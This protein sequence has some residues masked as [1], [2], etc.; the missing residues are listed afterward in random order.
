MFDND[1]AGQEASLR[2]LTLA[3][4]NNIFP[5]I[6]NLPDGFKDID[7]LANTPDGKKKF[8]EQREKSQDGFLVVFQN[9]KQKFDITSPIDKQ[10]ILNILFELIM[11]I[12]NINIQKHYLQLL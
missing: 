10:K 3:Y 2:A 6:I 5:K 9:L 1:S 8:D 7:E 12:D 11:Q 4:Q